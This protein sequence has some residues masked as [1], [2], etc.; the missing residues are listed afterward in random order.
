MLY[1]P[2][3]AHQKPAPRTSKRREKKKEE[4][5]LALLRGTRRNGPAGQQEKLGRLVL[6]SLAGSTY[7]PQFQYLLGWSPYCKSASQGGALVGP[8]IFFFPT[9]KQHFVR[10]AAPFC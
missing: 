2:S 1:R 8:L 5:W 4:G 9:K 10:K 6:V 7:G 3:R